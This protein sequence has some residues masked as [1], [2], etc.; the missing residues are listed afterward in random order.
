[1]TPAAVFEIA[2]RFIHKNNKGIEMAW[3]CQ[4]CGSRLTEKY[5]QAVDWDC[6][7]C[8]AFL[9]PVQEPITNTRALIEA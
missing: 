7:S 4:A 6:P 8:G 2:N 3:K 9:E 1:M 5:A